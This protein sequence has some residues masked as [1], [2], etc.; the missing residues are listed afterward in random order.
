METLTPLP[1]LTILA[2]EDNPADIYTLQRVL[3][4]HALTYKDLQ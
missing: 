3:T 4:T 2:V 1:P